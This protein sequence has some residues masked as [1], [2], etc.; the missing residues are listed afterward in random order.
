MR[1]NIIEITNHL[2]SY[3][4]L[5]VVIGL[6]HIMI[7]E[8]ELV[9]RFIKEKSKNIKQLIPIFKRSAY[10]V[11]GVLLVLF[12]YSI[13]NFLIDIIIPSSFSELDYSNIQ[14]NDFWSSIKYQS[15]YSGLIAV[16]GFIIAGI[17]LIFSG[18]GKW[19]VNLSKLFI[20]LSILY[21]VFV[22]FVAYA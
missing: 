12:S 21:L 4:W 10:I 20:T 9:I 18:G 2:L 15:Q 7:I 1:E 17:N 8:H 6:I 22:A 19:L 14:V 11:L 5:F 3:T 16:I 13:V